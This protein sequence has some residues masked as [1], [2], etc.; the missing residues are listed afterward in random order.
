MSELCID[1]GYD[2]NVKWEI[3]QLK[4]KLESR[5]ED[6]KG[7]R[8]SIAGINS[9]TGHL[10]H[11]NTYLDKKRNKLEEK[12][13]KLER[14]KRAVTEFNS[15]ATRI[16]KEVASG[17]KESSK[18]FCKD[19]NLGYG[20]FYTLGYYAGKGVEWL[21]KTGKKIADTVV[22]AVK[23][24][25]EWLKDEYNSA[26]VRDV[27]LAGVAV[28]ILAATIA[29]GGGALA[30]FAAGWG[31]LKAV[32]NM[33]FS[34]MAMLAHH[35]GNDALAE[36]LSGKGMKEIIQMGC[37]A[38]LGDELGNTVGSFVYHGL[39]IAA[40]AAGLC[41]AKGKISDAKYLKSVDNVEAKYGNMLTPETISGI[42]EGG[43]NVLI[44]LVVG[45]NKEASS[46][47]S[48]VK[49]LQNVLKF[50]SGVEQKGFFGI[51][52]MG[53]LKDLSGF[54]KDITSIF[55]PKYAATLPY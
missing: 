55:A 24:A 43:K 38:L 26:F 25:W 4:R 52:G 15:N 48:R 34:E 7:V 20:L 6:Y 22:G 51:F 33:A 45:F 41:G 28:V 54:Y 23:S 5:S 13:K 27:I 44:K 32:S 16:D 2:D 10:Y 9:N 42:Q 40:F 17:I 53:I 18:Q 21:K 50:F 29:S 35:D 14:F 19:N 36:K 12:T 11:A 49:N 39:N 37:S 31:A 8:N 47:S 1:F 3:G 46:A 30:I